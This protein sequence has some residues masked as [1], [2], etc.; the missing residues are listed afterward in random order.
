MADFCIGVEPLS[1]AEAVGIYKRTVRTEL[2]LKLAEIEKAYGVNSA[3]DF[4]ESYIRNAQ[5][6]FA[7]RAGL[8]YLAQVD[9]LVP[10]DA[11]Q[12][13]RDKQRLYEIYHMARNS[14]ICEQYGGCPANSPAA[15]RF[16]LEINCSEITDYR[17]QVRGQLSPSELSAFHWYIN[18][19]SVLRGQ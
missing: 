13:I 7:V 4:A 8:D 2:S 5:D 3:L 9:V 6:P 1:D 12:H 16:C 11:M 10:P 18:A 14:Y 19:I 17:R 15:A